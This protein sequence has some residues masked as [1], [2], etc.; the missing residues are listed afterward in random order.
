MS[1]NSLSSKDIKRGWHLIDVKGK[2]LGRVAGEIAKLLMGKQ[3]SNYVT[4][5]DNG[6]FVVVTNAK[7]IKVT[8]RKAEQKNYYHHSGYPGG[9]RTESFQ[10]LQKRRPE[11]IIVHAVKGM[12]PKN[13]LGKSMLKK[14]YVY[15]GDKHPYEKQLGGVN[16]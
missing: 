10:D 4:Y 16:G 12:L 7:A 9:L 6:D 15:E 1:T 13:K 11:E 2:V 8:G 14:L 5:L 3:K